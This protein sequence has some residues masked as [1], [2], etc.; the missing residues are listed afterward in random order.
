MPP[1]LFEDIVE[2]GDGTAATVEQMSSDVAA[3]LNWAAVPELEA[4]NRLG[5]QAMIFLA[6]LTVLFYFV[7]RKVW[8]N[9]H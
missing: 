7:K 5:L 9:V 8:R 3:F 4:R 6:L 1:P 2:Y